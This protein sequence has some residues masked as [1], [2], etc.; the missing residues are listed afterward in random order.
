MIGRGAHE[1]Q[2]ERHIDRVIEGQRL[3]RDQRLVVIHAHR[4][5]VGRA[6]P[7]MEHGVGRQRPERVDA[8]GLQP[9]DRRRH[10]GA[11]FL[12]E[13]AVF[14]GMRIETGDRDARAGDAETRA[15]SRARRCARSCTIR[16]VVSAATTSFSG[17]WMVTGT[18]ASSLDHSI[19]TGCTGFAGRLLRQPGQEFGM[20]RLGKARNDRARSW[21]PDW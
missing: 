16:S 12:A 4:H 1:R 18:T 8:L 9:R 13:R 14:A 3:D 20:A 6:R 2:A 19:I 5:V 10:D 15:P 21:R 11:I 17:K 7:L